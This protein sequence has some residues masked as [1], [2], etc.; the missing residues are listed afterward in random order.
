M[1]KPILP[2]RGFVQFVEKFT[3]AKPLQAGQ[4]KYGTS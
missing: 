1:E 2:R 3:E 4:I